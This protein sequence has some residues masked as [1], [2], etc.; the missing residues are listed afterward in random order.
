MRV[1]VPAVARSM[2]RTGTERPVVA[3]NL[4]KASGAKGLHHL[5][6]EVGQLN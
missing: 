6:Y 1:K 4:A 2:Q 3:M 5:P